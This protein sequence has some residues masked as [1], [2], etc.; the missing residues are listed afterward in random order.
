MSA[1]SRP[2]TGWSTATKLSTFSNRSAPL[3]TTRRKL[4]RNSINNQTN[5]LQR[6]KQ[7]KY[8]MEEL[9]NLYYSNDIKFDTFQ[10]QI[11]TGK[12]IPTSRTAPVLHNNSMNASINAF[13]SKHCVTREQ[14]SNSNLNGMLIFSKQV[15]IVIFILLSS[16]DDVQQQMS[17]VSKTKQIDEIC[18]TNE[19]ST[20]NPS[21]NRHISLPITI[22]TASNFPESFLS[23]EQNELCDP[24]LVKSVTFLEDPFN[25]LHERSD[26]PKQRPNSSK[27]ISSSSSPIPA[28]G[29]PSPSLMMMN[30]NNQNDK[31]KESPLSR[32]TSSQ[33]QNRPTIVTGSAIP[34]RQR[35]PIKSFL[36]KQ[37]AKS[38]TTPTTQLS[39][40]KSRPPSAYTHISIESDMPETPVCIGAQRT[41]SIPSKCSRYVL[42]TFPEVPLRYHAPTYVE[43]LLLPER[44]P[45][46]FQNI[47]HSYD[48]HSTNTS[49]YR[50]TK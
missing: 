16:Q 50:K 5:G 28:G 35:L 29:A 20:P 14:L 34:V 26:T 24:P 8:D 37:R 44:F 27:S 9:F 39:S 6:M 19:E 40:L 33:Q 12:R 32:I 17:H 49:H 46:L 25:D 18:E 41:V 3:V 42:V 30:N 13:D 23:N 2:T 4:F 45:T 7:S 21:S 43:R 48:S 31:R 36:T 38:N 22:P 47:L 15:C 1:R 10:K 11:V